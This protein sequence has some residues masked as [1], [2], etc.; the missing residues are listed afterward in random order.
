MA[1]AGEVVAFVLE[2]DSDQEYELRSLDPEGDTVL[3]VEAPARARVDGRALPRDVGPH[4]VEVYPV[5]APSAA[6]QFVVEVSET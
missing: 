5:D 4:T 6:E 1:E 3:A 2:N